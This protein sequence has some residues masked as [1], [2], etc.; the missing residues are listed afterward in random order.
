M[1]AIESQSVDSQTPEDRMDED[2]LEELEKLEAQVTQMAQQILHYRE[3]LPDQLKDIFA[4]TLIAQRPLLPL[5][6]YESEPGPSGDPNQGA[7]RDANSNKRVLA[8][9]NRETS[10][11][12]QLLK[13]KVSSNVSAMPI[14]LKRM[15]DCISRIDEL[16]S[17]NVI[18][19]PAFTRKWTST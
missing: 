14:V 10:E 6:E 5:V 4:S 18:L 1:A 17:Y 13:D 9:D 19:H 7:V 8:K 3:T 15:E 16:D 2:E 12:M 11:K